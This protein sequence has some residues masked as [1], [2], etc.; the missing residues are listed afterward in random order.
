MNK[1]VVGLDGNADPTAIGIGLLNGKVKVNVGN[2]I[3]EST[4]TMPTGVWTFIACVYD[5]TGLTL[6][7]NG[8]VAGSFSNVGVKLVSSSSPLTMGAYRNVSSGYATGFIA[9]DL[10]EVTLYGAALLGP[11]I[12]AVMQQ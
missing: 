4:S 12:Q 5:G 2:A 1:A 7:V 11:Q 3:A 6:Y 9:G 10:D 8:D